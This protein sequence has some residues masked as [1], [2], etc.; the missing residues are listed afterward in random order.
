MQF[1][2][3]DGST[4]KSETTSTLTSDFIDD[5]NEWLSEDGAE[6]VVELP[7]IK[8]VGGPNE[9]LEVIEG[10]I[11]DPVTEMGYE[12]DGILSMG[13]YYNEVNE[14]ALFNETLRNAT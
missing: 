7:E 3:L 12:T 10:Q 2:S 5:T 11:E 14:M 6:A 1:G 8:V 4:I 9:Q 13:T